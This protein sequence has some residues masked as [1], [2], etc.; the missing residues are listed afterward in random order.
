MSQ[1]T[2]G[3]WISR[4]D[5]SEVFISI[6][7]GTDVGVPGSIRVPRSSTQP[8]SPGPATPSSG[9]DRLPLNIPRSGGG[10]REIRPMGSRWSS[11]S[12]AMPLER[13]YQV[14]PN[15]PFGDHRPGQPQPTFGSS[16]PLPQNLGQVPSSP[17][18]Y[19][20]GGSSR[21]STAGSERPDTP[22]PTREDAIRTRITRAGVLNDTELSRVRDPNASFDYLTRMETEVRNR[23]SIHAARIRREQARQPA[24][25]PSSRPQSR[26]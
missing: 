18:L 2:Y 9:Q 21:P 17:T 25:G 19:R 8:T 22:T 5:G 4:G 1:R 12:D 14:N 3:S 16:P 23:L 7:D 11:S 6:R 26:R 13:D 20:M 24:Q 15:Q 10:V